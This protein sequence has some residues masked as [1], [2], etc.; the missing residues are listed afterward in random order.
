MTADRPTREERYAGVIMRAMGCK[1]EDDIP[2]GPC[3]DGSGM[4]HHERIWFCVEHD[5]HDDGNA[6]GVCGYA[7]TLAAALVAA[8]REDDPMTAERD[9]AVEAVIDEHDACSC[10]DLLD[11]PRAAHIAAALAPLL[12]ERER[13]AKAEAL[14][15][16]AAEYDPAGEHQA[17]GWVQGWLVDRAATYEQPGRDDAGGVA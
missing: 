12:D 10:P 8:D 16:A 4:C 5:W 14:A 15:E 9:T 2:E 17:R 7:M 11:Q 3:C 6:E 1:V 13:A